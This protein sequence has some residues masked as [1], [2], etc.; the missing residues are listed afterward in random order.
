MAP[1]AIT[2]S[3]VTS[4][5]LLYN[6]AITHLNDAVGS[7]AHFCGMRYQDE[8]LPVFAVEAAEQIDNL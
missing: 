5:S 4:L 8:G 6:A 3:F 1:G 2:S 7:L